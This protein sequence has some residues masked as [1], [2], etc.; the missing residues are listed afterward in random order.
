[1]L[2][3]DHI[4]GEQ[5]KH[6]DRSKHYSIARLLNNPELLRKLC[7]Q[8]RFDEIATEKILCSE[9]VRRQN[10]IAHLSDEAQKKSIEYILTNE[11]LLSTLKE[12]QDHHDS[13]NQPPKLGPRIEKQQAAN[14]VL[15]LGDADSLEKLAKELRNETSRTVLTKIMNTA[16]KRL[17]ELSSTSLPPPSAMR[18]TDSRRV[19]PIPESPRK[20]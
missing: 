3:I 8:M 9:A 12:Q 18:K 16:M 2:T 7:F 15:G 14:K 1:L 6:G 13:E 20:R 11:H 5:S 19:S 17:M 4:C 10:S